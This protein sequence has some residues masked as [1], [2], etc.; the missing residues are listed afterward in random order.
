M[1]VLYLTNYR[2]DDGAGIRHHGCITTMQQHTLVA[3]LVA[4][5][6]L[7]AL[8]CKPQGVDIDELTRLQQRNTLLRQEIAEMKTLIRRAGDEEPNLQE[9]LDTRNREVV[10]A[11]ETLKGLRTQETAL[12]MRRIELEGRLD[13]FRESFRELQNRV[14][15]SGK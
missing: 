15:N 11:Y 1:L 4:V 10:Q 5:F 6:T 9:R 7:S 12:R 14:V 13:S 3:T 2:L 8:G